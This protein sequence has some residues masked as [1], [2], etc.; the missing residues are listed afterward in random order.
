VINTQA[1]ER[2]IRRVKEKRIQLGESGAIV[3]LISIVQYFKAIDGRIQLTL[4]GSTAISRVYDKTE[5][6]LPEIFL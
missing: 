2:T 1:C 4:P 6:S 3:E 5:T